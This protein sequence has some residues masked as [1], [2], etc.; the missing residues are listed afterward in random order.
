[1][2]TDKEF[3]NG[4]YEKY[5]E[6]TKEKQENKQRNIKK[7]I[8][9]AAVIIVLISSIVVFFGNKPQQVVIENGKIQKEKDESFNSSL[10]TVGNFENFYNI[11]KEKYSSTQYSI[12]NGENIAIEED[13]KNDEVLES[14]RSDTNVQVQNVDE[15]DIVKVDNKYIYYV[16][17]KKVVIIDAEKPETSEKVAE[18]NFE[19]EKFYPREIYVNNQKL[20]IVG[21][22]YDDTIRTDTVEA[23]SVTGY[24][25]IKE[26]IINANDDSKS[27]VIIYDIT[28]VKEPKE[29][30][31][32][33]VDGMY[34]SSRKIENYIYFVVNKYI[35]TPGI[36]NYNLEELEQYQDQYKPKYIDTAVGEEEKYIDYDNIYCLDGTD[37]ANYLIL[38]GLNIDNEEE[39]EIQTFLG[40]GQYV[41][42]SEKN[43]YI[44]TNKITYGDDYEILS[45]NTH[46][47]K[48]ALNNGKFIFKAE[49]DVNGQINNQ[50]SMDENGDTFRIATTT[51]NIWTID[52]NTSN[53]LYILNDKLEEIGKVAEF[54][55]EEKIYSVRYVGDKAYVVTFK[56]TDPLFVIDLS[57]PSNPQILGELKIPGYSTYLHPY[58]ETHLIGFGYDTKEDGTQITTNGLKMVMFD[59]SDLNNPKELFK[60]NIGDSKYTYSELLFNHKA[61]LFSKEKN[62]I[63][64]PIYSSS[65]RK[66]YTRAAIYEIDLEKGFTLKGEIGTVTD[67][68]D[69]HVERI[70]FINGT[71]YTLS[72]SLIK[73][74]DMETLEV[75]KEI[76][77]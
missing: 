57:N 42:S 50:F 1:M 35:Y 52:E 49:A 45:E 46:I 34:L 4:I 20:T 47:L 40:A 25:S 54:A 43:M 60:I 3:I 70:V 69:E 48:V 77:I 44:A 76:E 9:I 22:E 12:F 14:M 62:I 73:V 27:G 21:N 68:A 74:A 55:K 15:A 37:E 11:I 19:E 16:S 51:G 64:F 56:Q 66:S 58:D 36:K 53:N 29:I 32:V 10:K 59:I 28:N 65:G 26:D 72:R 30:R 24:M 41:Y 61:L 13:N 38:V 23:G 31:R 8:N 18:I 71:Y 7:I 39:A 6:Y 5:D 17:G 67:N 2:K 63:A 75:I 33:M